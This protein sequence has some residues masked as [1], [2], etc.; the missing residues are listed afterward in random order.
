[1]GYRE[2]VHSMTA[3]QMRELISAIVEAV[4]A[5]MPYDI[6]QWWIDNKRVLGRVLREALLPPVRTV[7]IDAL[8][9]EGGYKKLHPEISDKH[10]PVYQHYDWDVEVEYLDL[11]TGNYNQ[12]VAE[13]RRRG[14]RP[15]EDP[16]VLRYDMRCPD[17]LAQ[18]GDVVILGS[19]WRLRGDRRPH[20][21]FLRHDRSGTRYVLFS[22][23]FDDHSK[24][25]RFAAIK[26]PKAG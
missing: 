1:M 13:M 16:E 4:P 6:A 10:A 20:V 24:G 21:L 8:I 3:D 12:A 23:W 15:A 9:K 11:G 25:A 7:S 19:E 14:Y 22:L 5:D 18:A 17:Q 26:L 2:T